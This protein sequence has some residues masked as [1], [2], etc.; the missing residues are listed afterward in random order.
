MLCGSRPQAC[1]YTHQME[2]SRSSSPSSQPR[3]S[4]EN[5][6]LL[7]MCKVQVT[8]VC[9]VNSF[10]P[11]TFKKLPK[12]LLN[13]IAPA[14]Q[15]VE[16]KIRR[17]KYPVYPLALFKKQ[18]EQKGIRIQYYKKKLCTFSKKSLFFTN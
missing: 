16:K 15:K 10:F 14:N 18:S 4:P 8:Q 11:S 6:P 9:R 7:E 17:Q 1:K 13:I 12:C 3:A 2:N 5:I